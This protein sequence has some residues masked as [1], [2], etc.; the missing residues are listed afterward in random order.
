MALMALAFYSYTKLHTDIVAV[1]GFHPPKINALQAFQ[2][3][4]ASWW[5]KISITLAGD[6]KKKLVVLAGSIF[7]AS[8]I[9]KPEFFAIQSWFAEDYAIRHGYADNPNKVFK[10]HWYHHL[11]P[12]Y[13]DRIIYE[14]KDGDYNLAQHQTRHTVFKWVMLVAGIGLLVNGLC[15]LIFVIHSTS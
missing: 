10:G 15:I 11:I 8:W 4:H 7:M 5:Q 2:S 6:G 9:M 13:R 1:T 3:A 14:I 12:N